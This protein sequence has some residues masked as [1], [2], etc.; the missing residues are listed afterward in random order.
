MR[1]IGFNLN[2]VLAE[3]NQQLKPVNSINTD[4]EIIKIE[5]DKVEKLKDIEVIKIDFRFTV[6]Y[7]KKDEKKDSSERQAKVE[8]EGN[9]VLSAEKEEAKDI[10]KHKKKDLPVSIKVPLNNAIFKKCLVK[11]MHFEEELGLPFHIPVPQAT[12]QGNK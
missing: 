11:A 12:I 5:S 3:K 2:K 4:I 1:I 6:S 10:I 8:F 7:E 9:L